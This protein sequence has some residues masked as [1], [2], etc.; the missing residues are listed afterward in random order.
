[1]LNM[2]HRY[3]GVQPFR[4]EQAHL[5]FGRAEDTE[6]LFDL[7]LL[8]KL[9]V[10]FG[11]SGYGKSSLLNAGILPRIEEASAK[12]RQR[13][14]A[15]QVRF[16]AWN[17]RDTLLEKFIFHCS[18]DLEKHR[19]ESVSPQAIQGVPES[20]WSL[21]KF[22]RL[23]PDTTFILLF[24]QFEEF[25]TYPEVQQ[26]EFKRQLAELLYADVPTYVKQNED[27]H[28]PEEIAFL[29][30]KM[31]VKT[32]FSIRADR[33]SDLDRLKDKL[34]A[35]LHKR[36]ELQA[37]ST[38]QAREAL[39]EPARKTGDFLSQP[40]D[41]SE[42]ALSRI[43]DEFSH[44]KQGREV[45]VEAF[46][47]QVLAQNVENQIIRGEI[48][49]RDGNGTPDVSPEDLPADLSNIFS[50]Y[51]HNKIN[52]LPESQRL[53]ARVLIEEGLVFA[54]AEG[55]ARRLSMDADVLMQQSGAD[56]ELLKALED[57]FLLRREVNTTGGW[58]YELSHD[59]LLKPVLD[60]REERRGEEQRELERLEAE[61]AL[62][63]ATELEALA[64]AE[65][66]RAEAAERLKNEAVA[67]RQH[68]ETAKR[69]AQKMTFFA[70]GLAILASLASVFAVL[71]TR[72]AQAAKETAE[73]AEQKATAV[74]DKIYFYQDRFGLDYDKGADRYGFIDKNLTTKIAF[75]YEEALPFEA[76]GF[77]KVKREGAYFFIDTL[78][79]EY[80]LATEL[81]QLSPAITA[82]DLRGKGLRE[83]PDTVWKSV[84]LKVLWLSSNQLQSLPTQI[85]G[86]KK[87]QSL[88]LGSNQLQSLPGA[89]GGLKNLKSLY[90]YTNQLQS[91]PEDIGALKSLQSLVLR[92]NQLQ[93]LPR[94]IGELK[95]LQ[96][97][98][99]SFNPIQIL[100]EE[101]GELKNLQLLD[102]GST[103]LQSLPGAIG[104]LKNLQSLDLS[105]NKLQSLPG[106][107]GELKNLQS[108]Y[109]SRNKLQILPG[110][111]GELTS[112]Q[113]LNLGG[114]QLQNLPGE[115]GELTSLQSLNLGGNQLQNLPGEIGELTSLQSLN[116]SGNQ[117]QNLPREIGELKSLRSLNLNGNPLQILPEKICELKSLQ[118]LNL[119][120][121]QLQSLPEEIGELKGL[122]S[123]DLGVNQLQSLPGEIGAL[124]NLQSLDLSG[125]N[126]K[127]LPIAVLGQMPNLKEIILASESG[128]N[129]LPDAA[130][131][132][133]R[134]AMPWCN[135]EPTSFFEEGEQYEEERKQYE[136][137]TKKGEVTLKSKPN[138]MNAQKAVAGT[139]NNLGWYQL[140]TGQ[141]SEAEN[142]IRRGLALDAT[143]IYLLANLAP[144]LLL[145]GKTA[146]AIQEYEKWKDQ[147]FGK[148][149]LPYYRDAFLQDL[150]ELE[151]AADIIPEARAADVAAVRKLLGE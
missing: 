86:L 50:E 51:Y 94:T 136:A 82:L 130:V 126:L 40:F 108:L 114:N 33:M 21:L 7:I 149:N 116:L 151:S 52:E 18:N 104:E 69:K 20:L 99:L 93:S 41:W 124:K 109:L 110:Q 66:Q 127:T 111:I 31:D 19:T 115:I 6:R 146:E 24:D 68:A 98:Y 22:A 143:N 10:L 105:R 100:P 112:L 72:E 55:D 1:M 137:A 81:S 60:W 128:T 120:N 26:Q 30:E 15:V 45:G 34:P 138:D 59:T 134:A 12:G 44:D 62:A 88:D 53:P 83:I 79:Q 85:G 57:T 113:S 106:A 77:A 47:L 123:L 25:F 89:I 65:R 78:G 131:A 80:P 3:P 73:T 103:Q 95:N 23:G 70:I 39:V 76:S 92:F 49:D 71:K 4:K 148:N 48:A 16:N 140:L 132:T 84:Q 38:T 63:R 144:A 58:N 11:K 43:L 74:L 102:L 8:E 121:N 90:L 122:Q 17:G 64:A 101:I 145:Q 46:L 135:I 54:S 147:P 118:S 5:F 119:S 129:P 107:I 9:V 29:R 97:L 133:L 36:R 125:N 67:A 96:S 28:S 139:Y 2:I 141:F 35:I 91:L 87:L 142:S 14:L 61:K 42:K 56:H 13:Y 32:V 37:L 117:L 75:Q 27:R 150:A